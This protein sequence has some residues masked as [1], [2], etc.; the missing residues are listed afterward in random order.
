MNR[1]IRIGLLAG[2]VLASGGALARAP[3]SAELH[4]S[5]MTLGRQDCT[6]QVGTR[7]AGI[8]RF[9]LDQRAAGEV[10]IAL[11][12]R[13]LRDAKEGADFVAASYDAGRVTRQHLEWCNVRLGGPN[14]SNPHAAFL[15]DFA[16]CALDPEAVLPQ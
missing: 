11:M 10:S 9:G 13:C 14:P 1:T 16:R 12:G 2:L 4:T 5:L 8:R 7:M 3:G 15:G 6:N